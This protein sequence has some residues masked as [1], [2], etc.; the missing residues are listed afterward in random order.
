MTEVDLTWSSMASCLGEGH[1]AATPPLSREGLPQG[2]AADEDGAALAAAER[3]KQATYH[4][5]LRGGLQRLMVL[6]ARAERGGRWSTGAQGL[7]RDLAPPA[8]RRAA[9]T[10]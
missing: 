6:G 3:R 4:Q 9:A 8:F 10:A 5:L 2:R 1:H 7:V